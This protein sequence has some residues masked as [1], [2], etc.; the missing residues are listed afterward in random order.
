MLGD[1][2]PTGYLILF[3]DV[4]LKVHL[5]RLTVLTSKVQRR[6]DRIPK[7]DVVLVEVA[8]KAVFIPPLGGPLCRLLSVAGELVGRAIVLGPPVNRDIVEAVDEDGLVLIEHRRPVVVALDDP[9]AVGV[10]LHSIEVMLAGRCACCERSS[11]EELA[12]THSDC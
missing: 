6:A 11:E 7:V 5:G 3:K 8:L 12:S 4:L 10:P 1:V 9:L 2:V